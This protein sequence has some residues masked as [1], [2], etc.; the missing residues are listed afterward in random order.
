VYLCDAIL[1]LVEVRPAAEWWLRVQWVGIACIPAAYLHLSDALLATTGLERPRGRWAARVAYV[2][3]LAFVVLALLSD[4]LVVNGVTGVYAAPHLRAGPLFWVFSLYFLLTLVLGGA[5]LLRAWRRCLT[6]TARYR[7]RY[8]LFS[9]RRRPP[10]HSR[11][12]SSPGPSPATRA[13][14][15]ALFYVLLFVVTA[16][17]CDARWP[18]RPT[19]V[20]ARP[21][22]CARMVKFLVRSAGQHRDAG[23]GRRGAPRRPLLGVPAEDAVTVVAGRNL[24]LQ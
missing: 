1:A 18:T 2:F 14:L 15:R 17:G 5:N 24:L 4:W 16:R 8:L 9:F 11:A 6:P 23:G 20:L 13:G 10:A 22:V 19:G 7:M 21:R 3:S 12:W